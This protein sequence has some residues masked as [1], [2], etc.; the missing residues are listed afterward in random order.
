MSVC[1]LCL[2][3]HWALRRVRLNHSHLPSSVP[4]FGLR[5]PGSRSL[6]SGIICSKPLI[7]V[8]AVLQCVLSCIWD[9]RPGISTR[10]V[11]PVLRE[12][13]GSSDLLVMSFLG[14]LRMLLALFCCWGMLLVCVHPGLWG[15]SLQSCFPHSL[16]LVH[17]DMELFLS[18]WG[19]C[20]SH[21]WTPWAL[22]LPISPVC[23]GVSTIP[24]C[25]RRSSRFAVC[26]H[27]EGSPV[28]WPDH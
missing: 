10:C 17:T 5:N 2:S 28:Q 27:F 19:H 20:V 15:S 16:P 6:F 7:I 8:M 26:K 14:Q 4:F 13:E 3:V 1:V 9:L 22:F 23:Q 18:G 25:L 12:G 24:W 11:S 21:C